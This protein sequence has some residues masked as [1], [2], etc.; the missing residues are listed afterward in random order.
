M[1][2]R[3]ELN[4]VPYW[5][6]ITTYTNIPW[7]VHV[8]SMVTRL[9][10]LTIEFLHNIVPHYL[11]LPCVIFLE[12]PHQVDEY[13][14]D[15]F[16]LW[17]QLITEN[18]MEFLFKFYTLLIHLLHGLCTTFPHSSCDSI[19]WC[20]LDLWSMIHVT[21]NISCNTFLHFFLM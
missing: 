9:W 16:L 7:S 14:G 21:Y 4:R 11:Y 2:E 13:I 5:I 12:I 15:I 1:I 6:S 19:M 3:E 8:L 17:S 18:L 10:L 20:Y